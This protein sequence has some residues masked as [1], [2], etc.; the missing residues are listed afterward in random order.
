MF[1]SLQSQSYV[2]QPRQRHGKGVETLARPERT[3][4]SNFSSFFLLL[5]FIN[6]LEWPPSVYDISVTFLCCADML[7]S[8]DWDTWKDIAGLR[9]HSKLAV[10]AGLLPRFG[11]RA[12]STMGT[13]RVSGWCTRLHRP[14]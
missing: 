4:R 12:G 10:V 7:R 9:G 13:S 2:R 1:V 8:M 6:T 11:G 3:E 14:I 5:V